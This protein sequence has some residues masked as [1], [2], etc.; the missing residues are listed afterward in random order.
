MYHYSPFS[1]KNPLSLLILGLLRKTRKKA[2]FLPW[3]SKEVVDGPMVGRTALDA[4]K[5][6]GD[7]KISCA[8]DE[9]S[10]LFPWSQ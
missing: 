4:G 5:N 7:K 10:A 6:A 1:S 8:V 3:L 9:T 2:I